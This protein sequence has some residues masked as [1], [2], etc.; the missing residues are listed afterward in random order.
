MGTL[1]DKL[2][3]LLGTNRKAPVKE[4]DLVPIPS[5]DRTEELSPVVA[6]Y[7]DLLDNELYVADAT[8]KHLEDSRLKTELDWFK[9]QIPIILSD[10]DYIFWDSK[11]N[12]IIYAK[13]MKGT[14]GERLY[15]VV[16][17]VEER[18]IFTAFRKADIFKNKERYKEVYRK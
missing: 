18:R 15:C 14:V 9:Q 1:P 13:R 4:G 6:V 2:I 7:K 11:E 16:T 12:A 10:P 8:L 5:K 3:E 17:G